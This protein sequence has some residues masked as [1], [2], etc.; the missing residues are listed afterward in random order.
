M[1]EAE[2]PSCRRPTFHVGDTILAR[3]TREDGCRKLVSLPQ[4]GKYWPCTPDTEPLDSLA[5][6]LQDPCP[7]LHSRA[8]CLNLRVSWTASVMSSPRGFAVWKWPVDALH[9]GD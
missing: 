9:L 5:S 1:S 2:W 7:S 3:G 6:G 8:S 4:A